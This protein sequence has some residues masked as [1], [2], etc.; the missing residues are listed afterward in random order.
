M[1]ARWMEAY[2]LAAENA[3][4]ARVRLIISGLEVACAMS[5][6]S[7]SSETMTA[8]YSLTVCWAPL[9]YA[10]LRIVSMLV[11]W[12]PICRTLLR[13]DRSVSSF[14]PVLSTLSV[15]AAKALAA[16]SVCCRTTSTLLVVLPRERESGPAE[17][18]RSSWSM[19]AR[20]VAC[21]VIVVSSCMCSSCAMSLSESL[22]RKPPSVVAATTGRVSS[23]TSRVLMRQ[24]CMARREPGPLG[25][26]GIATSCSAGPAGSAGP[27]FA[28]TLAFT[29]FPRPFAF[30]A[31]EVSGPAPSTAGPRF[32]ACWGEEPRSVPPRGSCSA[33]ALPSLLN[34][35]CTSVA[36]SGP[37]VPPGDRWDGVES[38]GI[39]RPMVVVGDRRVFLSVP[40]RSAQCRATC[41]PADS[42]GGL[43][44]SSTV[45]DLQQG[46]SVGPESRLRR[47]T[48]E[49]RDVRLHSVE[50]GLTPSKQ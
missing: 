23:D 17:R 10:R 44:N 11:S 35:P 34:R 32:W 33:A 16:V 18:S 15:A 14:S 8:L 5:W 39:C 38:W 29:D 19:A 27:A 45:A 26:F 25:A 4:R 3:A 1:I 37:G 50:I 47:V 6:E 12:R 2:S 41:A 48:N 28:L 7:E 40:P 42:R 30:T 20:L 9:M 31:A 43:A 24:F 21:R 36:T 46:A 22:I 13:I 49:L